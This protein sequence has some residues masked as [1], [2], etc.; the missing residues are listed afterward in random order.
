V[1]AVTP[2]SPP[3]TSELRPPR[4][5][6]IAAG[7][8]LLAFLAFSVGRRARPSVAPAAAAPEPM[9]TVAPADQLASAIAELQ[10]LPPIQPLPLERFHAALEGAGAS[11]RGHLL[12]DGRPPPPLPQGAPS[13]VR[14]GVVIVR[15]DGAQL[16]PPGAPTRDQA[17]AHATTLLAIARRDFAAAVGA[18]DPGSAADLGVIERG[19]LEPATQYAIFTLPEGGVSEVLDTPRGLWIARRIR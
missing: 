6:S 3:P 14:I 18:G 2:A 11:D 16:A 19:I 10:R 17:L 8:L 1:P 4:G 13:R 5:A 15:Y 12:P 7:L 9:P